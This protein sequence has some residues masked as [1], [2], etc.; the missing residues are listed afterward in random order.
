VGEAV[1]FLEAFVN[2][3]SQDAAYATKPRPVPGADLG[4]QGL[5]DDV[6]RLMA[7]YWNST[8]EGERVRT[9]DKYDTARLFSGCPRVRM[10]A[11]SPTRT[12]RA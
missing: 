1:A 6:V 3:L 2:E 5:S 9:L 10:A 12:C 11:A 7:A 8:D 4:L